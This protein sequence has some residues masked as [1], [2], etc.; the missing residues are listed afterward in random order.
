[1]FLFSLIIFFYS[2]STGR[3]CDRTYRD[4]NIVMKYKSVSKSYRFAYSFLW[5]S[6]DLVLWEAYWM[7]VLGIISASLTLFLAILYNILGWAITEILVWA[8]LALYCIIEFGLLIGLLKRYSS[9]FY[10][11]YDVDRLTICMSK[12]NMK[13]KRKC[14]VIRVYPRNGEAFYLYEIVCGNLIKRS[15]AAQSKK[16]LQLGTY[17]A[18][19][20]TAKKP[21][22]V[23]E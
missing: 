4:K 15:H 6:G 8:I 22:W 16:L 11:F 17:Y 14:K 12:L 5:L 21:F 18:Y 9:Q 23:I 20:Q 10:R 3:S 7:E 1:M 13:P 2:R 19:H